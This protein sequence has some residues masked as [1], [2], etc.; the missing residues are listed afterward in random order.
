[1]EFDRL[2]YVMLWLNFMDRPDKYLVKVATLLGI[3]I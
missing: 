1:M 3:R 2:R